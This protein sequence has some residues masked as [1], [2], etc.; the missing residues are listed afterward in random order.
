MTA[1][2]IDRMRFM[3]CPAC[4]K[5]GFIDYLGN[6]RWKCRHCGIETEEEEE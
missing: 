6:N 5:V 4:R 3:L 1:E 2:E